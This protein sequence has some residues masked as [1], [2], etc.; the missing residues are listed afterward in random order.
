MSRDPRI[1]VYVPPKKYDIVKVL[2][3]KPESTYTIT[4]E[5]PQTQTTIVMNLAKPIRPGFCYATIL[6]PKLMVKTKPDVS[7]SP[8]SSFT[9]TATTP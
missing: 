5:Y 8:S 9:V 2:D 7:T 3:L 4:L 1:R 6:S